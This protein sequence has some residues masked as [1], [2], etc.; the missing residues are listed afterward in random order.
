MTFRKNLC[1]KYHHLLPLNSIKDIYHFQ[2]EN[3]LTLFLLLFFLIEREPN[4]LLDVNLPCVNTLSSS[5]FSS[6]FCVCVGSFGCCIFVG[7]WFQQ[8]LLIEYGILFQ[9]LVFC[10][11]ICFFNSFLWN[12]YFWWLS[13]WYNV[14]IK[15]YNFFKY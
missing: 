4:F 6:V 3:I 9:N 14:S 13:V 2:P 1:L 10:F 7:L 11:C 15:S 5:F 8:C 12:I